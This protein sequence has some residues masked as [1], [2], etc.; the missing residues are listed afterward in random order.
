MTAVYPLHRLEGKYEILEKLQEGGMGAVYKVRHRLLGEERVVKVMRPHLQQDETLRARFLQEA[1]AAARL[2]HPNIARIFDF[3]FDDEGVAYIVM[4]LIRGATLGDL[5]RAEERP[6]VSLVLE[7]A[8]QSLQAIGYIHRQQIVHRDIAPDNLM[9]GRD[10]GGRPLVKLIDLGLAKAI[11]GS[12]DGQLTGAG[13]FVGKF[14]YAAPE[15]F[16][17]ASGA[18]Q[19]FSADLYAFALVLYELSTGKYPIS[20]DNPSSLIAGHLFRP[21]MD[22]A[23]SDPEGRVP[24]T[25]RAA[26]R[27]GL[28]KSPEERFST[29]EEFVAA[30]AE[31]ETEGDPAETE[32]ILAWTQ[33]PLDV[34]R[35]PAGGPGSSTQA[36]FDRHF[37][38]EP[39]PAP[40]GDSSLLQGIDPE[41]ET[42]VLPPSPGDGGSALVQAA[43]ASRPSA[44]GDAGGAIEAA[45][46]EIEEA[47]AEGELSAARD[48]LQQA[49][50]VHGRAP[51]LRE[52]EGRIS[53]IEEIAN[54]P[55][56]RDLLEQAQKAANQDRHGA[57]LDLL[58]QA[59]D[60]APGD[61]QVVALRAT[62]QQ[63]LRQE[64][65]RDERQALIAERA[66]EIVALLEG[67]RIDDAAA[68]LERA[69]ETFGPDPKWGELQ[70]RIAEL[71]GQETVTDLGSPVPIPPIPSIGAPVAPEASSAAQGNG[72]EE[73]LASAHR[74][75]QN[76]DFAAAKE[77]LEQLL[78][79]EPEHR[80]ARATLVSVDACLQFRDEEVEQ[81][82]AIERTVTDLREMLHAGRSEAAAAA[83]DR[84]QTA[85][86]DHKELV[87]MRYEVARARLDE[88]SVASEPVSDGSTSPEAGTEAAP[89]PPPIPAAASP[90]PPEP[91]IPPVA[92]PPEP[93]PQNVAEGSVL[94]GEPSP[95]PSTAFQVPGHTLAETMAEIETQVGDGKVGRA[96]EILQ[97][98]VQEF[99]QIPELRAARSRLSLLLLDRD[100]EQNA[101]SARIDPFGTVPSLQ[102]PTQGIA[103]GAPA[104]AAGP[105]R[106]SA[107]GA[108]V[109]ELTLDGRS[110]LPEPA[111]A[112]PASPTSAVGTS[113]SPP[114]PS[115]SA[116]HRGG[117]SRSHGGLELDTGFRTTTTELWS[118]TQRKA[119]PSEPG[120]RRLGKAALAVA[121]L[122]ALGLALTFLS[123][124]ADFGGG[125]A[126]VEDPAAA[127]LPPGFLYFDAVPWAEIVTLTNEA[128]EE[129]PI[130]PFITSSRYTPV[131]WH[132][133]PGKYR[134][135]ARY[136]GSEET[137]ELDLEIVSGETV[138]QNVV[139]REVSGSEYFSAMGW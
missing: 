97:Q 29:A 109:L 78:E 44:A 60:L 123:R 62:E 68:S 135:V 4:E 131:V 43:E 84:A 69:V 99:G 96:L 127:D 79:R 50:A 92:T 19:P 101:A 23:I 87:G 21:P 58:D 14:R 25:L 55:L 128:G 100:A 32:R 136:P 76:E 119:L 117:H 37:S 2:S 36:R 75:A 105:A 108:S 91:P 137:R 134:L 90:A 130:T 82:A 48:R 77:L 86:G 106:P 13:I 112:S 81:T 56:V 132:L 129:V 22:F 35:I 18:E 83:L 122:L 71:R 33:G 124:T 80:E 30:L 88:E 103:T 116:P 94:Q 67:D 120:G 17:A 57:A 39:T 95:T 31:V 51:Q 47:I 27:R 70:A 6:P 125:E 38:P 102:N 85:F 111:A 72:I 20:G 10:D 110:P 114:A 41:Q 5:V 121:L 93:S 65:E 1:Q 139:F 8:R 15:H 115:P 28:A 9:L 7:I 45:V 46:E 42:V 61:P 12:K 73:L 74:K 133:P 53:E 126:P 104:A 107:P 66:R 34:P 40:P 54:R 138:E 113:V 26:L 63:L 52:L 11:E 118:G 59:W 3:T 98:A 89:P 64:E 24:E 16:E 49:E